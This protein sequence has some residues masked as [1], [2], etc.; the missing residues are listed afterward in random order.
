[1]PAFFVAVAEVKPTIPATE[2]IVLEPTMIIAPDGI[3]AQAEMARRVPKD[4]PTD[5]LKF[6]V[7]P[8]AYT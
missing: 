8:L 4:V 6:I 2:S 1:M 7:M 3:R 5:A